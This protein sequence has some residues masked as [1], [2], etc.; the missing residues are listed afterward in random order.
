MGSFDTA[1]FLGALLAF[2][3]GTA[4]AKA[5]QAFVAYRL[6]DRLPRSEGRLSL[7][8]GRQHEP[9]GLLLALFLAVGINTVAW[10]KPLNLNPFANRARRF[11][12]TLIGLTGPLAY[13]FLGLLSGFL[14]NLLLNF[15]SSGI[16]T[17]PIWTKTAYYFAYF[18]VLYAAFNLLP[19]PPLDGHLIFIK[20]LLPPQWDTKLVW[21]ET[22]GAVILLVLVLLLPFFIRINLL[23]LFFDPIVSI[24]MRL[25]GLP[26][27]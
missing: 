22:Y 7:N 9:L 14:F 12:L 6:G 16:T 4:F 24:F 13:L 15:G 25:I 26:T 17:L 19:I 8:P 10:G 27:S 5:C 20:G 23:Y 1:Y 3:F 2:V 11:G 21:L 18:N